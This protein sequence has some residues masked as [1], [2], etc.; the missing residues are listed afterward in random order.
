VSVGLSA[1]AVESAFVAACEEELMAPKPGN[2]HDFAAGHGMRPGDFRRSAEAAA[3]ALTH[4]GARLGERILGAV[5][6]TRQAVGQ[7]TNLGIVLLCA[8]LAMAAAAGGELAASLGSIL[9]ASNLA[10]ASA[11]FEAIALASPGGLGT[12]ARYDV[13]Q[14]ATVPLAV[15]MAEAEARDRIAWNWTHRFA[16]IFGP[17]LAAY[18]AARQRWSAPG[19]AALAVY[20]RFLAAIPDSHVRRKHGDA[21]AEKIRAAAMPVLAGLLECHDPTPELPGLLAWD[22]ALKAASINP[23]TSADLTVATIFAARLRC[24]LRHV[25]DAC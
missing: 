24:E 16:D 1:A 23:G 8:P 20:L 4:D 6:A 25:I 5:A 14:P 21:V 18:A 10:D 7:N 13:H 9:A 17:G 19:W 11:V 12:A 15:A 3:P 2:V 22:A